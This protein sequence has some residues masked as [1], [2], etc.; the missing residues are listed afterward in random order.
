MKILPISSPAAKE[1][2]QGV[3]K[4]GGLVIVPTDTIYGIIGDARNAGAIAKIFEAKKRSPSQ[5]LGIFVGDRAMLEEYAEVPPQYVDSLF[6]CW[7]GS[8]TGV[9][10]SKG[11]LPKIL[12]GGTGNVGIRIPRSFF[13]TG[14]LGKLKS[15]LVQTSANISG[16]GSYTK[17]QDVRED[18]NGSDL[19]DLFI[20]AGNLPDTIPSTGVDFTQGPP[21]IFREGLLSK[22]E[23]EK[24]FH[25]AFQ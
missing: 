12:E 19:I 24:I 21:R 25:T 7:P 13:I 14:L 17:S 15:P 3:L 22:E 11:V 8:L 16:R 23:L 18:F 1:S 5:A 4:K 2:A 6:R 10:R 20:D 9:F